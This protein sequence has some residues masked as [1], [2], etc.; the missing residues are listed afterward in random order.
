MDDVSKI[1]WLGFVTNITALK[2]A[3]WEVTNKSKYKNWRDSENSEAS[4][5]YLYLRH[6]VH[7]LIARIRYTP[8]E[9]VNGNL[10]FLTHEKNQRVKPP[11]YVSERDYN[12]SD[13]QPM[14]EAIIEIQ[15]QRPK[16]S[17]Q[18]QSAYVIK[19]TA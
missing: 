6:S 13:I 11:R 9:V 7:R 8:Y 4:H 10:D 5:D 3:G 1:E 12:E 19:L 16:R 18:L 2:Y 17:K 14:L 15:K